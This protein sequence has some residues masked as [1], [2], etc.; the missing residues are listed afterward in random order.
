MEK[1]MPRAATN[2]TPAAQSHAMPPFHDKIILPRT[3]KKTMRFAGDL[4][5]EKTG[6]NRAAAHWYEIGVFSR[7]VGG[8]VASIKLFHKSGDQRDRFIAER[9]DTLEEVMS[10]IEIYCPHDDIAIAFDPAS[11]ALSAAQVTILAARLRGQQA[12]FAQAYEAVSGDILHTLDEFSRL[13]DAK[14]L[15]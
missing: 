3:G 13:K 6:Y 9:Y 12:T 10:A 4:I 14:R 7:V 11:T 2:Q 8:F 1:T 5:T 15:P